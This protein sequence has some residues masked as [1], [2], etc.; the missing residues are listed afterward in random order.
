MRVIRLML[1]TTLRVV[2][3]KKS[4]SKFIDSVGT[5]PNDTTIIVSFKLLK[6][7]SSPLYVSLTSWSIQRS[8]IYDVDVAYVNQYLL[9]ARE[10][11]SSVQ[12]KSLLRKSTW[13]WQVGGVP[14]E[15]TNTTP[16]SMQTVESTTSCFKHS[17]LSIYPS[18]PLNY[19]R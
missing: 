10:T 14:R 9:S 4:S 17:Q 16:S 5:N 7:R 2:S 13:Y 6:T 15:P 19:G 8:C 11:H 12:E 18:L 3:I 1:I